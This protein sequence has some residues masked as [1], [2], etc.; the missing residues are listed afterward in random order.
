MSPTILPFGTRR[1]PNLVKYVTVWTLAG[2]AIG[3]SLFALVDMFG[4]EIQ[5]CQASRLTLPTSTS[6]STQGSHYLSCSLAL[7]SAIG[8]VKKRQNET[9]PEFNKGNQLNANE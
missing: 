2:F 5:K 7:P 4:K 6:S 8:S 9:K 3:F 1:K